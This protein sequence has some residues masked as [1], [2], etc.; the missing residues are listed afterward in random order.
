[1]PTLRL[2]VTNF[3]ERAHERLLEQ[4]LRALPGVYCAVANCAGRCIEIDFEDD[5]VS[6]HQIVT[7]LAAIGFDAHLAS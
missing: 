5:D 6:I 4:T 2:C 3:T 1:M 7:A